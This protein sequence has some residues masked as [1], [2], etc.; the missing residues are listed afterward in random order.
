MDIPSGNLNIFNNIIS[1][2]HLLQSRYDANIISLNNR[3]KSIY[4]ENSFLQKKLD[5][6]TEKI[7]ISKEENM[8]FLESTQELT[9]QKDSLLKESREHNNTVEKLNCEVQ[10]YKSLVHT[11]EDDRKQ[12]TKVSHVIMIEK[13]NCKLKK[14]I[15][16]LRERLKNNTSDPPQPR[17]WP[18]Q[19]H[20]SPGFGHPDPPTIQDQITQMKGMLGISCEDIGSFSDR[21]PLLEPVVEP[22]VVSEEPMVEPVIV[23]EEPVIVSE[24][25]VIVSEEPVVVS[26]EP[27]IV[28]EEE[29]CEIDVYEKKI[30]GKKYYVSND[31][32]MRIFEINPDKSI[33]KL[34]GFLERKGNNNDNESQKLKVKWY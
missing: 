31:S 13:E 32:E 18:H 5:E 17:F 26:E 24:E 4:D 34:L 8:R 33:G 2:L 25:P 15:E 1:D 27:V 21:F 7:R 16:E 29:K 14:E 3:I 11:L 6:L 10:H 23:S 9:F 12:F 20:R 22:V 19:I 30:K 28:S